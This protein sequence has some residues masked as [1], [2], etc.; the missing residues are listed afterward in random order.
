MQFLV[1]AVIAVKI[2]DNRLCFVT[3]APFSALMLIVRQQK[4]HPA[5]EL[6]CHDNSQKF[7]FRDCL[8]VGVHGSQGLLFPGSTTVETRPHLGPNPIHR[9]PPRTTHIH[10]LALTLIPDPNQVL[11]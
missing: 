8:T 5:C 3:F 6:F 7:I 1:N 9:V 2:G 4:A 11:M 10:N